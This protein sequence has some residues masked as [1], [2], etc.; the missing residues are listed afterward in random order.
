LFPLSPPLLPAEGPEGTREEEDPGTP[1]I[2][3]K[4]S[5]VNARRNKVAEKAV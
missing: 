1:H 2:K 3:A 4:L 5:F